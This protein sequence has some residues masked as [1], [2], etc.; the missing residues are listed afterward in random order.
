[1][2]YHVWRKRRS[3]GRDK[4]SCLGN[5]ESGNVIN[6]AGNAVVHLSHLALEQTEE[7][8]RNILYDEVHH[9]L[10]KRKLRVHLCYNH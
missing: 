3:V 6:A 2:Q 7:N 8:A 9:A 4:I 5:V 1:M 10:R